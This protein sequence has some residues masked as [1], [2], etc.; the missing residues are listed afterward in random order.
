MNLVQLQVGLA[1]FFRRYERELDPPT[2]RLY[3]EAEA[4]RTKKLGLWSDPTSVAPWDFRRAQ[5]GQ[6]F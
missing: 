1:W 6:G 5:R 3:T 2:R 4:A